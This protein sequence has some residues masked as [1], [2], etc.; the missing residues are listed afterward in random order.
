MTTSDDRDRRTPCEIE[1]GVWRMLAGDLYKDRRAV[2]REGISNGADAIHERLQTEPC[3][4]LIKLYMDGNDQII[5]DWGTGIVDLGRFT[6]ISVPSYKKMQRQPGRI[7]YFG[8]G[9]TS[10]LVHSAI[11]SVDFESVNNMVGMTLN[12]G[13]D[14]EDRLTY[15]NP[16]HCDRGLLMNHKGLKVRIKEV[17]KEKRMPTAKLIEY[18]G[19]TF[20]P[21]IALDGYRIII[22]T[23]GKEFEVRP[24]SDF[25]PEYKEIFKLSDGSSVIGNIRKGQNLGRVE[26]YKK[27]Y[28]LRH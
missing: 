16:V 23:N 4:K 8:V 28:E 12:L 3:D 21:K 6:R 14:N 7:G 17:P 11:E 18:I 19:L 10:Y 5:E 24:P 25:N 2:I 26:V 13:P 1:P 15:S 9:K 27:V 20:A 22:D